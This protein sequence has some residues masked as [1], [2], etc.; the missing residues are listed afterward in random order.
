MGY[1]VENI[2]FIQDPLYK[3]QALLQT[4]LAM[5]R[6]DKP[7]K[8]ALSF[9]LEVFCVFLSD[10]SSL[11]F[12]LPKIFAEKNSTKRDASW[13]ILSCERKN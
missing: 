7:S 9:F 5:V 11:K 6:E 13:K 1:D 8:A 12:C 3:I 10:I 2:H 4:P